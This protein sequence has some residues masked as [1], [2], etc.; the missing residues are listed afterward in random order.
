MADGLLV[1]ALSEC[2]TDGISTSVTGVVA[3]NGGGGK[4]AK[5]AG[6]EVEIVAHKMLLAAHSPYFKTLLGSNMVESKT[7]RIDLVDVSLSVIREVLSY[8]YTGKC[9]AALE[10]LD[11]SGRSAG[12][13]AGTG[14][15]PMDFV[16]ANR[17]FRC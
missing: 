12:A 6:A 3:Q 11:T 17:F 2:A 15:D 10:D 5:P 7:G 1:L 8:V 13:G 9:S 16:G 14:I 4:E